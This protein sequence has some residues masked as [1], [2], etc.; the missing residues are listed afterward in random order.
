MT[1]NCN[2]NCYTNTGSNSNFNN[3]NAFIPTVYNNDIEYFLLGPSSE[4]DRRAST[5]ITKQL[6]RD[7]EDIFSGIGC[8]DG[9]CSL[10]IKPDSKPY[11]APQRHVEYALQKPFNEELERL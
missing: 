10:Q 8:F 5:E 3:S 7:F 2:P 1:Q 9:M 4:N 6:Q 11:Q